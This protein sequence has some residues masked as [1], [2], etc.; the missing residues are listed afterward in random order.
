MEAF[1]ES[2]CDLPFQTLK[3]ALKPLKPCRLVGEEFITVYYFF[4]AK[5]EK[6][7]PR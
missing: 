1:A 5:A 7:K 2:R 6:G 4:R 3:T